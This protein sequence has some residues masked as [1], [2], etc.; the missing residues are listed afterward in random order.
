MRAIADPLLAELVSIA[1]Q[2]NISGYVALARSITEP[3]SPRAEAAIKFNRF[4]RA[5]PR[6]EIGTFR[7]GGCRSFAYPKRSGAVPGASAGPQRWVIRLPSRRHG[8][9]GNLIFD[10]IFDI[11]EA[12][13]AD[14]KIA[15]L[16]S[17]P[18]APAWWTDPWDGLGI[19]EG[20]LFSPSG[21]SSRESRVFRLW[22]VSGQTLQL[23]LFEKLT[24]PFVHS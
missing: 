20:V 15:L 14:Q 22:D 1:R 7:P 6:R 16:R 24:E 10:T 17:K 12:A 4:S 11:A 8:L 3:I 2:R 19:G 13:W 5:A 23:R 18:Q 9:G 21:Y